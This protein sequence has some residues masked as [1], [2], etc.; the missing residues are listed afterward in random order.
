[1]IRNGDRATVATIGG[2]TSAAT[3]VHAAPAL[4]A[5]SGTREIVLRLTGGAA[6]LPGA[7]V[8]VR[9]GDQQRQAVSLPREAVSPDGYVL[10]LQNGRTAL[11]S[12]AVGGD[13]G[14]ARVEILSW[15]SPGERV[16]PQAVAGR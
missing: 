15:L 4:D 10:V 8:T 16:A 3:V 12:V 14:G 7:N 2:A 6:F 9:L 13:V 11:R 1:M 5:A